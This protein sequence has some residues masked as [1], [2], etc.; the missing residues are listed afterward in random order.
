[1]TLLPLWFQKSTDK[2][3]AR[4]RDGDASST[5]SAKGGA[6]R[7]TNPSRLQQRVLEQRGKH[8]EEIAE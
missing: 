2:E 6:C 3:R 7:V 8:K 1:M 5:H 4:E